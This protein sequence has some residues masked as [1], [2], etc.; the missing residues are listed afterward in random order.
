MEDFINEWGDVIKFILSCITLIGIVW[1]VLKKLNTMEK[2]VSIIPEMQKSL[3]DTI[4]E[5]KTFKTDHESYE[6]MIKE[7]KVNL[8]KHCA[9][10]KEKQK[11]AF[12]L[13]RF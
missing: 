1:G 7:L 11:M 8:D 5:F 3:Q 9:K 12:L 6:D 2:N 10:D 4:E 13:H